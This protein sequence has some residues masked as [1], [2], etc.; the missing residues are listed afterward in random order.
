MIVEQQV[1]FDSEQWLKQQ[2]DAGNNQ[3]KMARLAGVSRKVISRQ[4]KKFGI[5][6]LSSSD[7]QQYRFDNS[8]RSEQWLKQQISL[9]CGQSEMAR[10]A[11]VSL[12][13]LR[14]WLKKFDLQSLSMSEVQHCRWEDED[15]R[16]KYLAAITDDRRKNNS[17]ISKQLWED[18]SY[19][20]KVI[21]AT[22]EA[23]S[24][25]EVKINRAEA[26]RKLWLDDAFRQRHLAAMRI[27][28]TGP[29][30]EA[31]RVESLK[32][33]WLDDTFRQTHLPIMQA[34]LFRPEVN[35]KRAESVK[36][37]WEDSA[38]RQKMAII[39][40]SQPRVSS[41]QTLLYSLLDDLGVKYYREYQDKPADSE[42]LIGPWTFDCVVPRENKPSLLIECQG[43]YWH[44]LPKTEARDRSK[45][46]YIAN[47]FS[48]VYELKQIW[49]HEFA[50]K[51][52]IIET[53][54]YW[55]GIAEVDAVE[56]DFAD[57][58]I[59]DCPALDYRL[60]LSKYH[61][62]PNAGRGG[63]VYGAYLDNE[64]VAVCI[65]SPPVRQNIRTNGVDY[66]E[67]CELSRLCVSPRFRKKNL[68]SWFV[69]RCIKLLDGRFKLIVSYC[70]TT[71]NHNGAIYRAC[72][73]KPDG[74]VNPDYWYVSNDG[75][76]MHKR[77]LYGHAVKM[78]MTELEFANK[79]NY[80]KVF[81]SKKLRFILIPGDINIRPAYDQ[82]SGPN[83]FTDEIG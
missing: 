3:T 5:Q 58:V 66:N 38:H 36:K 77:T 7:V 62:L 83:N 9:G 60:L 44:S 14:K 39:C 59:K 43:E 40:A 74:E 24:R 52:K 32:K 67:V 4:L 54:K 28:M 29:E 26:S 61:Y 35:I 53:L 42:C 22:R 49:E 25:P 64:L 65:F 81:G 79:H 48:N 18:D 57:L 11:D 55:L 50:F 8:C 46:S 31:K 82:I 19:R 2:I 76:V 47:N 71:Y 70:D 41:I 56:Y 34:A 12:G 27:V 20:K 6:P 72:N 37:L 23:V 33:L 17:E 1:C 63:I 30:V 21:L 69:S 10:L 15:N 78:A 45:A 73:F 68:L 51:N 13:T 75:W 16:A 80:K